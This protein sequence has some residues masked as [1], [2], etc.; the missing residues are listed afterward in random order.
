MSP[1]AGS[2]DVQG[3]SSHSAKN[4][5]SSGPDIAKC[6]SYEAPTHATPVSLPRFRRGSLVLLELVPIG[7]LI[8]TTSRCMPDGEDETSKRV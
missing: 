1:G 8:D 5:A 6:D 3:R 4:R 2:S 7:R